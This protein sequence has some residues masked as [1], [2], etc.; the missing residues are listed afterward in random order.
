MK[1]Q[2]RIKSLLASNPVAWYASQLLILALACAITAKLSWML[3][4]PGETGIVM[5]APAGIALAALLMGGA[6]LWPGILLGV[7]AAH[8]A[9][10]IP[11]AASL[12]LA[13]AD[14]L[15]SVMGWFLVS[16]NK[17]FSASLDRVEDF[18]RLLIGGALL[19][20][21]VSATLG[22]AAHCYNGTFGW[23][24]YGRQ[25]IA[26][27]MSGA[28]GIL[29]LT[30]VILVWMTGR[31]LPD[32]R[33]RLWELFS[34]LG[35]IILLSVATFPGTHLHDNSSADWLI[36]ASF[37]LVIWA[38]LRF[39][40]HGVASASLILAVLVIVWSSQGF[41][42]EPFGGAEYFRQ[43]SFHWAFLLCIAGTSMLTATAM[44]ERRGMIDQARESESR[45]KLLFAMTEDGVVVHRN[46]GIVEA[47]QVYARMLGFDDPSDLMGRSTMEFVAPGSRPIVQERYDKQLEG[48]CRV[49]FLRRDGIEFSTE[50]NAKNVVREGWIDRVVIVRDITQQVNEEE[51]HKIAIERLVENQAAIQELSRLDSDDLNRLCQ[52][53]TEAAARTLRI[54]RAGIWRFNRNYEELVCVDFYDT[55]R[56]FH[57]IGEVLD[58]R[59]LGVY[60]ENL[61][62]NL[63]LVVDDVLHDFR[64]QELTA[65]YLIPMGITSSLEIPIRVHGLLSGVVRLEQTKSLRHWSEDAVNFATAIEGIVAQAFAHH[66]RRRAEIAL[67]ESE[68]RFRCL[69]EGAPDAI[70]MMDSHGRI[71][72]W[73]A[74]A[75]RIFGYSRVEAIGRYLHELLAPGDYHEAFHRGFNAF[76]SSGQGGV[77]GRVLELFALRKD[78]TRFPVE[79][80]ISAVKLHQESVAIAVIRDITRRRELEEKTRQLGRAVEQSPALIVITDMAGKVEYVNPKFTEVTGYTYAEAMGQNP[81]ML[82]SGDK[83]SEEYR[84]LWQ[85]IRAG[86][87]W[88]GEFHNRKKN[89]ELYWE[90]ASISPIRDVGGTITH[91]VAVKEDIT[92][93]KQIETEREALLKELREAMTNIKTMSGLVPICSGCKKIRDDSGYWNQLETFIQKHSDAK[94]SHSLCPDCCK[95]FF[96]DIRI[97]QNPATER[98]VPIADTPPISIK[99]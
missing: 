52:K 89:G 62:S 93:R 41:G 1:M 39:H 82:K 88:R 56:D 31:L 91:Y 48:R 96:P 63:A 79:L 47:N 85:T 99:R 9:N 29:L 95:I 33:G 24:Y 27:W 51:E 20:P 60:C 68:A 74:A 25:W 32:E 35:L 94:F 21:L 10:G 53:V 4:L 71:T 83:T 73:N 72:F 97:N 50:I 15:G 65:S 44:G 2:S 70:V 13:T 59:N 66:E 76:K 58:T 98:G 17:R 46:G 57:C 55:S 5:F 18:L 34:I 12:G 87:E 43:M 7:F 8:L 75:E 92:A 19:S 45:F 77:I 64:M 54:N 78:Q 30:P 84:Q 40:Q 3:G 14:T 42:F 61:E 16:R 22:I 23:D 86:Q 90:L 69:S 38:A 37:P 80:C 11:A 28:T 6:R 67:S 49:Q 36:F 81:R 26:W